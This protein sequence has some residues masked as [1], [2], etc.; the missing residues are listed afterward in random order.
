[1]EK[2]IKRLK[3]EHEDESNFKVVEQFIDQIVVP[4][5]K[6]GKIYLMETLMQFVNTIKSMT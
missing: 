6:K 2:F 4:P 3:Y 5:H 1:M